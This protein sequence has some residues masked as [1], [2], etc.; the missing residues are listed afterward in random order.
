VFFLRCASGQ[1]ARQ[2]HGQINIQTLI[3]IL[4][5]LYQDSG[6]K[7]KDEDEIKA[8]IDMYVRYFM[9][10]ILILI[11]VSLQDRKRLEALEDNG[12]C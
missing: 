3:A 9:F 5:T 7:H 2:T 11:F 8:D 10:Q 1:T 12:A 6:A 4:S